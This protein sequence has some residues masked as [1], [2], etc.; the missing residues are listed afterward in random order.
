MVVYRRVE[1]VRR[2][3]GSRIGAVIGVALGLGLA[4]ALLLLSV[5]I[6]I[7][8]LPVILVVFLIARWRWRK[9]M[10]E[11]ASRTGGRDAAKTIEIDYE[12][13]GKQDDGDPPARP[14]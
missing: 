1:F 2:G 12:V 3:W 5:S 8:L 4:A 7:V 9:L 10:A 14:R 11:A 6:A 13:V